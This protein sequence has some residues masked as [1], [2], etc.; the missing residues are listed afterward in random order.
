MMASSAKAPITTGIWPMPLGDD[1]LSRYFDGCAVCERDASRPGEIAEG[2]LHSV[3]TI[4]LD[5][6]LKRALEAHC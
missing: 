3:S 1:Y 2:A 4:L 5:K 6:K